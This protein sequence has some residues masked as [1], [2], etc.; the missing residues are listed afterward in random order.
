MAVSPDVVGWRGMTDIF[1]RVWEN[2]TGRLD[3]PLHFRLIIQPTVAAVLAIRAGWKDGRA[4]KP[5]FFWTLLSHSG[6]RRELLRE[7]WRDL[8]KLL[9]IA[10]I[11]DIVYQLMVHRGVYL[12]ELL[13]TI[14]CLGII[15]YILIR[16]PVTRIA[17]RRT[18][19]T[20]AN[21]QRF[22]MP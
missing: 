4:G 11:L 7:G 10:T 13:I 3:G 9:T 2:L 17:R 14:T 22:T 15:P 18:P 20:H 8:G 1:T 19:A 12:L 6:H 5:A 16:G 21:D